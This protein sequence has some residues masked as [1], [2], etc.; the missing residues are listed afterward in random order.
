MQ[1]VFTDLKNIGTPDVIAICNKYVP[2]PVKRFFKKF[3]EYL[4]KEG[5]ENSYDKNLLFSYMLGHNLKEKNK[6]DI[7]WFASKFFDFQIE[8]YENRVNEYIESLLTVK[9]PYVKVYMHHLTQ[10]FRYNT[11]DFVIDEKDFEE[12]TKDLTEDDRNKNDCFTNIKT[13]SKYYSKDTS[14]RVFRG[15]VKNHFIE[16]K[17]PYHQS[18]QA[19]VNA[20]RAKKEKEIVEGP[21]Q[22]LKQDADV[23]DIGKKIYLFF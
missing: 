15:F 5:I 14:Q 9:N 6:A 12:I 3:A 8:E 18:A 10:L 23:M 2:K 17:M 1:N 7:L 21:A 22:E 11:S 20:Y 16:Q 19:I 4:K 13:F